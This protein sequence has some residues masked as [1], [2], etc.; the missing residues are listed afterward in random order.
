MESQELGRLQSKVVGP[1]RT[2]F[3]PI[4]HWKTQ[5]MYWVSQRWHNIKFRI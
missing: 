5:Q 3:S 2:T 1:Y 4:L